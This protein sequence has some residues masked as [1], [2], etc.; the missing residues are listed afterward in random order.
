MKNIIKLLF[1]TLLLV[2]A[3]QSTSIKNEDVLGSWIDL[4]EA[5]LNFTLSE[6]GVAR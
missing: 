3:C 6:N 2:V 1:V 4:S 5:K